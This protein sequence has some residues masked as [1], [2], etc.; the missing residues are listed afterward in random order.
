MGERARITF[1][2]LAG[3]RFKHVAVEHERIGL[4][5]RIHAGSA[6]IRL[7]QHVGRFNAAP[8]DEGR[9]VEGLTK[10][11]RVFIDL[12]GR[13]RQMHFFAE[14]IGDAQVHVLAVVVLDHLQYI[15][16]GRHI[17]LSYFD[18]GSVL[19]PSRPTGSAA[20]PLRGKN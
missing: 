18:G 17:H 12:I 6:R 16:S 14:Q 4:T 13:N 9:T 3:R 8:A 5:E 15:S 11:K 7:Q 1:I 19:E 2:A 20:V 10:F